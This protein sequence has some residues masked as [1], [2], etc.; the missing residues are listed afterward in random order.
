MQSGVCAEVF[1]LSFAKDGKTKP[2]EP[3][4]SH[5]R[6]KGPRGDTWAEIKSKRKKIGS[7]TALEAA[8]IIKH[9]NRKIPA[10]PVAFDKLRDRAL[11]LSHL[12]K[13][14]LEMPQE[15]S[16]LDSALAA[17]SRTQQPR[18]SL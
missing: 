2:K 15:A 12:L 8:R 11:A 18:L 10:S 7:Q 4:K 13:V 16:A 9:L 5:P 3:K 14:G 6:K 17:V 1:A